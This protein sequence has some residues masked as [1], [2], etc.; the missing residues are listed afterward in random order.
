MIRRFIGRTSQSR[1]VTYTL[2]MT[3]RAYSKRTSDLDILLG[4]KSD[5][6]AAPRVAQA[7]KVEGRP[8]CW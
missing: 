8:W 5:L 7:T 1:L 2:G 4:E 3:V 6:T